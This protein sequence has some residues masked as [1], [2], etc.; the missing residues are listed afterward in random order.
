MLFTEVT[1]AI[2]YERRDLGKKLLDARTNLIDMHL[3]Q[4]LKNEICF[5]LPL[6]SKY[7]ATSI[8]R[9]FYKMTLIIREAL[10]I[11]NHIS[12]IS[13]KIISKFE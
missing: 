7:P 13:Y 3:I 9:Y 4:S 12:N 10:S 11:V 5:D 6:F 8:N 1:I 2:S